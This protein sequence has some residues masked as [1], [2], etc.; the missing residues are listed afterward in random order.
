MLHNIQAVLPQVDRLFLTLNQFEHVP[1]EIAGNE[2]IVTVIPDD[3]L[4]DVGKFHFQPDPDDLI[5]T[6]DDDLVYPADYVAHMLS[7]TEH[8]D[9]DTTLIGLHGL[10]PDAEAPSGWK[11]YHFRR[12]MKS[13]RGVTR[14]GTGVALMKGTTYPPLAAMR[15]AEGY[16][17]IRFAQWQ[18]AQGNLM[19][20]VPRTRGWVK[21]NVPD[22]LQKYS[23]TERY[24]FRPTPQHQA[25]TRKLLQT[26]AANDGFRYF[27]WK[28]L[29]R[30]GG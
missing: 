20:T 5:F 16:V 30:S 17:D 24:L 11:Y 10:S 15:G 4:L 27:Q 18:I 8:M 3:D 13:I 9:F 6:M 14:L 12:G 29:H 23:L 21:G 2:R 25:E 28:K 7:F 26:T 22:E 19:W 1:D